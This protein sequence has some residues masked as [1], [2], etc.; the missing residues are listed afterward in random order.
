MLS[1][2]SYNFFGGCTFSYSAMSVGKLT[3]FSYP[4]YEKS[5]DYYHTSICPS[6]KEKKYLIFVSQ[7]TGFNS[8]LIYSN[9]SFRF[10]RGYMFKPLIS[11][12]NTTAELQSSK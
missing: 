3:F 4:K 1:S 2:T 6:M 7:R 5:D 9:S 12:V 8:V 11:S 10:N